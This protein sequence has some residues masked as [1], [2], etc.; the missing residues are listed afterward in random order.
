MTDPTT[1]R[2][3]SIGGSD[4]PAILG[5]SPWR[6]PLDV[7]R[8]KVLRKVD[9]VDSPAIRAGVR[10]EA[11]VREAY[12]RTLPEGSTV[13]TG[14]P[15]ADGWRRYTADGIA[16]V[17]GWD[18]L[19]EVKTTSAGGEWGE[20]GSDEVPPHCV[21]QGLW[22]MDLLGL[23]ECDYPML[24]WPRDLRGVIG[25]PPIEIVAEIGI[26]VLSVRYSTPAAKA[27]RS[28][29]TEFWERNVLAEVPPP[30]VDLEDAK[31]M[32]RAI[33]GKSVE[34]SNAEIE[35]L[36][37]RDRIKDEIK[38]MQE[39]VEG[40]ELELRKAIGDAERATRDG[41]DVLTL[42]TIKRA[43]YVVAPTE[44]RPLTTTKAWKQVTK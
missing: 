9:A 12:M 19:V 17:H 35:H 36:M 3:A 8:E 32:T 18:R 24:A 5:L 2:T 10:F 1:D 4:V 37:Q 7:W 30:P 16:S 27:V 6:T 22:G 33:A 21:A 23:E 34:L 42:K 44:Y 15:F 40:H 29:V 11:P 38:R 31:R 28:K 14:E 26:R 39:Q 41:V 20:E 13:I 25:L 43:G